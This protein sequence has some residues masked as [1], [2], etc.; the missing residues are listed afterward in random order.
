MESK[1]IIGKWNDNPV[2]MKKDTTSNPNFVARKVDWDDDGSKYKTKRETS[3]I[4]SRNRKHHSNQDQQKDEKGKWN[5][6]QEKDNK[7]RWNEDQQKDKEIIYKRSEGRWNED[8]EQL[9][10]IKEVKADVCVEDD[11]ESSSLQSFIQ[12]IAP[13]FNKKREKDGRS[14]K[15]DNLSPDTTEYD[16]KEHLKDFEINCRIDRVV[17]PKNE[18]GKCKGFGFINLYS[19]EDA[20]LIVETI[21]KTALNYTIIEAY[22]D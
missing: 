20:L 18:K 16:I 11:N 10:F 15:L 4:F 14:V 17:I 22:I 9:K 5:E 8:G 13:S 3:N 19:N 7:G 6:D 12:N 1:P 2:K 21:H